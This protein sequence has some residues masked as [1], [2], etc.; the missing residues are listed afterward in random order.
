MTAIT[1]QDYKAALKLPIEG[2]NAW[3]HGLSKENKAMAIAYDVLN[4]IRLKHFD[5]RRFNRYVQIEVSGKQR[6]VKDIFTKKTE[7]HELLNAKST[8]CTV[9]AMGGA[10]LCAV[11]L[12]DN[13]PI[14]DYRERDEILEEI[15]TEPD[16]WGD[17][18]YENRDSEVV[19]DIEIDDDAIEDKLLEAFT[20]N[21]YRAMEAAFEG[22][23]VSMDMGFAKEQIFEKWMEKTFEGK[24]DGDARMRVIAM[25]IIR[26]KGKFTVKGLDFNA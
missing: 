19:V 10:F 20:E 3:Y 16:D 14:D 24:D 12:G 5:F 26:N 11:R 18:N 4:E 25:N 22:N 6:T 1:K 7:L 21:E 2:R 23:T 9:C 15:S 17:K 8:S 13:A